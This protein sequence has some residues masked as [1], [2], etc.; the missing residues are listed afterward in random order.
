MGTLEYK[1]TK[2]AQALLSLKYALEDFNHLVDPDE[3]QYRTYRDSLIQRFEYSVDLFWKYLA[4][5]LTETLAAPEANGPAPTIRAICAAGFLSDDEGEL[6]L[7][8]I[9][10]RNKTSH[11]YVEELAEQLSRQ[12]PAFHILM[13]EVINRLPLK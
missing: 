9:K 10:A 12:I 7:E 11:M 2:L 13:N 6:A 4:K 8:M 5:Y 3:R 1:K